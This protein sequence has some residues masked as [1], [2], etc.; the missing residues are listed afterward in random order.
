MFV[1]LKEQAAIQIRPAQSD[2]RPAFQIRGKEE[3]EKGQQK[4]QGREQ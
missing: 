1:Q 2:G 4:G 3:Q